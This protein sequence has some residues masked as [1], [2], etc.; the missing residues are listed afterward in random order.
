MAVSDAYVFPGSVTAVLTQLSFQGHRL[1][2]SH[3]SRGENR[4]HAIKKGS[5][6]WI[7]N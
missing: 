7:S 6:N 1:P 5:L 2:F 3:A 4:K